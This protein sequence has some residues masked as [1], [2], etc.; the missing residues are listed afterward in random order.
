MGLT[1]EM[2]FRSDSNFRLNHFEMALHCHIGD[3]QTPLQE[4]ANKGHTEVVK[5]LIE[6]GA[7]INMKNVS[8]MSVMG[9]IV[10]EFILLNH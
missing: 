10:I 9:M 5:L 7:D 1:F 4:A 3:F 2:N 6:Q 8:N